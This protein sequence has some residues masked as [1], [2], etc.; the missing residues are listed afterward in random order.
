M[1]GPLVEP[2]SVPEWLRPLVKVSGEADSRTFTR[3]TPPED[4]YT[5]ALLADTPSMET[6]LAA[7]GA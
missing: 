5:K 1:I 6:A 2:E 7:A 3:F 4:A